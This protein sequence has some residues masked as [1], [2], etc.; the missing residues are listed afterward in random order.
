MSFC[1]DWF[2]GA[3]R[4]GRGLVFTSG[5]A[6]THNYPKPKWQICWHKP[7]ATSFNRLGG[8]NAWEPILVYGDV[9]GRIGQDYIQINTLNL[10]KGPEKDHP[11]PKP[12]ALMT[13]L[14][15]GLSKEGDTIADIFCGAGTT[16]VAC[17]E[18]NRH[19][20]G[21]E[22]NEKYCEI[23]KKRLRA[24]CK[25]LFRDEPKP[26]KEDAELWTKQ[27]EAQGRDGV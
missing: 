18:L 14:V 9:R 15:R 27:S 23:A 4:L 10:K 2:L 7:A 8:Y 13:W 25:P 5:I 1:N 6:N 20:I 22:I 16:L 3:S 12:K 11:C 19:G 17:K 26:R 24:T 21:I